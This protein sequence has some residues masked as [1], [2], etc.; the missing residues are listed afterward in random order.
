MKKE[1]KEN[2]LIGIIVIFVSVFLLIIG[3]YYMVKDFNKKEIIY[4]NCV[5]EAN[6]DECDILHCR[7]E[8]N[9]DSEYQDKLLLEEQNCRLKRLE[10]NLR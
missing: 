3:M 8:N 4:Q 9:Y 6:T 1:S 5:K 10:E 7:A 2:L